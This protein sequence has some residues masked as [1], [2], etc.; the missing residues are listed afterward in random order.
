MSTKDHIQWCSPCHYTTDIRTQ[1]IQPHYSSVQRRVTLASGAS[2]NWIQI[3]QSSARNCA[4][5][6]CSHVCVC[7]CVC[8]CV[9]VTIPF[10]TSRSCLCS[11]DSGKLS[12]IRPDS[13]FEE[14]FYLCSSNQSAWNSYQWRSKHFL[15]FVFKL[16]FKTDL[17][18]LAIA[19]LACF[20]P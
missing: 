20:P 18:E 10:I 5:L 13:E 17:F 16:T 8:V 12:F 14:G 1:Q 3:N 4:W 7:V 2:A 15:P 9:W 6:N 11:A 19:T